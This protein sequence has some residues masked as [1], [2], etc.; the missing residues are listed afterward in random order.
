MKNLEIERKFLVAG[1]YKAFAKSA[2]HIVQGYICR[3]PQR[4]VRIRIRDDR[5]Y[6]TVKGITSD[7]GTS[8]FE[9]EKEIPSDD[10]R[11]L[12][13]LCL[14]GVIDKTRYL[15]EVGKHL[16]EIDEFHGAHE[17]LV[18]A[19]IELRS[20]DEYFEK[21]DWLGQEVTGD[22]RYYNSNLK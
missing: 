8:R 18:L 20:S 22:P 10:A 2:H 7:D 5:G 6:I 3:D 13:N 16:F 21:P 4:T 14:P 1:D 12:L 9:W 19:E 11:A 17:G 15:V